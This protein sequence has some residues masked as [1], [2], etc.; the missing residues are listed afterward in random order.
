MKTRLSKEEFV[1]L[2][3]TRILYRSELIDFVRKEFVDMLHKFNGKVY[4]KRFV[5][6]FQGLPQYGHIQVSQTGVDEIEIGVYNPGTYRPL[7]WIHIEVPINGDGRIVADN[8]E[9]VGDLITYGDC[10]NPNS[11]RLRNYQKYSERLAKAIE[12]YDE[13]I[14]LLK[15]LEQMI[16]KANH[17][18]GCTRD[19]IASF[20]H[21][22]I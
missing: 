18:P 3:Q 8:W 17:L 15:A 7:E 19:N 4:N 10:K 22:F 16:D 14:K 12:T 6:A 2:I 21:L 11:N 20:L 5:N 13:D 9:F 1:E